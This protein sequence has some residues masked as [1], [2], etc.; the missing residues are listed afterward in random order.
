MTNVCSALKSLYQFNVLDD[1]SALKV[2]FFG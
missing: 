2:D 1:R